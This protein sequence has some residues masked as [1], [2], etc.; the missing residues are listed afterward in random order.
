MQNFKRIGQMIRGTAWVSGLVLLM[1]IPGSAQAAEDL[2]TWS[3]ISEGFRREATI[4]RL[5]AA[6]VP[7]RLDQAP[8]DQTLARRDPTIAAGFDAL[9]RPRDTR[10]LLVSK[11]RQ[12]IYEAYAEDWL[13]QSTPLGYSMSKSLTALAVGKALCGGAIASLQQRGDVL[14]PALKGTAWGNATLEQLLRMQSGS[15]FQEPSRSGWQSEAVAVENRGV[16][17]GRMVGSYIDLM[18]RHDERRFPPGE[19]FQYNN[20]DTTALG[21][22][23]EAATGRKFPDFFNETVWQPAGPRQTGAWLVNGAGQTATYAGFSAAPEDWIRL[24][25]FVIEAM[26]KPDDCFARYL[27]EAIKPAQKTFIPSRCYGYQIWNWCSTDSF[28]FFGY[29]GQYLVINPRRAVVMYAHQASNTNDPPMMA[30][31][32]RVLKLP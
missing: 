4:A 25:H 13:R 30:L 19:Q 27:A 18:R 9:M 28:M 29:G 15:S 12:V 10:I 24:G 11:D 21:L 14:I 32:Q 26:S 22:T 23:V 8:P 5:P 31:Y 6:G 20:Y 3:A 16:Y 1:L 7:S 2:Q 17:T